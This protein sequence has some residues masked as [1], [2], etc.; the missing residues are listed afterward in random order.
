MH[1]TF[2]VHQDGGA[3]SACFGR[4][5]HAE[6]SRILRNVLAAQAWTAGSAPPPLLSLCVRTAAIY[7]TTSL[8]EFH[9]KQQ[10]ETGQDGD[11]HQVLAAGGP[12]DREATWDAAF[13]LL[14]QHFLRLVPCH[15]YEQFLESVLCAL[16]V[17]GHYDCT[18]KQLTQYVLLFFPRGMKRFRAQRYVDRV[19]TPAINCLTKCSRLEELYLERADGPGVTTYL[20]AHI[21]KFLNSL[22]V[23]A[24]PKQ[25]DD[26]VASILG[27]NCPK[28]ESVVLTG[29][30]VTN[31][32][33]SWLLCC[34]NLHT[35]IMPGT[36][37]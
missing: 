7:A 21:L 34:R 28:L 36:F 16:E 29:T 5:R 26:D 12:Q 27:I 32:G 20:L 31:V 22:R 2:S 19:L 6:L 24:L 14:D 8:Y 1:S 15:V 25:C 18:G 9:A 17:A 3:S 10:E 30:G 4:R 37:F 11:H 23:L 35:I 13:P 33:L